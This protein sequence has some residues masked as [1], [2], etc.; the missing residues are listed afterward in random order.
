MKNCINKLNEAEKLDDT[1]T[2]D[3]LCTDDEYSYPTSCD[4]LCAR[5]MNVIVNGIHGILHACDFVESC[6]IDDTNGNFV[7]RYSF[8]KEIL[9]NMCQFMPE[10]K[11]INVVKQHMHSNASGMRYPKFSAMVDVVHNRF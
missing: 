6:A 11:H 4:E 3:V 2:I 10:L 9:E 5:V 1:T 8:A 7:S